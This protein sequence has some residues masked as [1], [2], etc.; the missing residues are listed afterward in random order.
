MTKDVVGKKM[1][2]GFLFHGPK[3]LLVRKHNPDWQAGLLNGVG[4]VIEEN[5]TPPQ[6]VERE[7][8]EETGFK[9]PINWRHFATEVEPFGAYVYFFS[10]QGEGRDHAWPIRN[11]VGEELSWLDTNDLPFVRKV[12]NLAWLIPLALDWRDL[13]PVV[14]TAHRDIREKSTW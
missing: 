9:T 8:R 7:F 13:D 2:V 3:V 1:V 11:D 14:V 5:E 6:A 4:G 10:T 12:G